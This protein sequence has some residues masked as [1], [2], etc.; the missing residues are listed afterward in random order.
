MF[1]SANNLP[2][3]FKVSNDFGTHKTQIKDTINLWSEAGK[4]FFDLADTSNISLP[5]MDSY[6]D[7]PNGIHLVDAADWEGSASALAVTVS[8]GTRSGSNILLTISHILVNLNY[9]FYYDEADADGS[10]YHLPSVVLHESGHVLGLGH[11]SS[12]SAVMYPYL[13]A[14]DVYT[15]LNVVDLQDIASLYKIRGEYYSPLSRNLASSNS[16]KK[17]ENHALIAG[18]SNVEEGGDVQIVQE[19]RTDHMCYHY[20]NGKLY[21]KHAYDP[22]ELQK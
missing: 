17:K 6:H 20:I 15:D 4:D 18:L 16:S 22:K 10:N 14:Y 11:S 7:K 3:K 19:L 5:S 8:Y 9:D 13:G 21:E 12:E 1:W 2:L